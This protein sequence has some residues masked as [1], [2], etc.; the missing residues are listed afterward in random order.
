MPTLL[1]TLSVLFLLL[2]PAVFGA[3]LYL[4]PAPRPLTVA[5]RLR[6]PSDLIL[7]KRQ[8]SALML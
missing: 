8:A 5:I 3:S 4:D 1:V 7:T 6:L 2:P